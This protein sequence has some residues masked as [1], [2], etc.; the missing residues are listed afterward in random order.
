MA[1]I[2]TADVL[3]LVVGMERLE[4]RFRSDLR[5]LLRASAADRQTEIRH[6]PSGHARGMRLPLDVQ[7]LVVDAVVRWMDESLPP[8]GA[9]AHETGRVSA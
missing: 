1:A 9:E 7:P 8:A 3:F 6:V 2:S 4:H 5:A